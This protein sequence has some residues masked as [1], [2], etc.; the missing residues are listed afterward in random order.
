ML[1]KPDIKGIDNILQ[2]NDDLK[3]L[4]SNTEYKAIV[5][6]YVLNTNNNS[7]IFNSCYEEVFSTSK[8][9]LSIDG[10][11]YTV[12]FSS[13]DLIVHKLEP[14]N[15]SFLIG[16][17]IIKANNKS[18]LYGAIKYDKELKKKYDI[19]LNT[20]KD[21]YEMKIA[22]K[23]YDHKG[24]CVGQPL[25]SVKG[26][27]KELS[28]THKTNCIKKDSEKQRKNNSIIGKFIR[29]FPSQHVGKVISKRINNYGENKLVVESIDGH[30]MEVYDHP[31]C[32]AI[33]R[34]SSVRKNK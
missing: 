12:L 7:F 23:W 33:L 18:D 30:I 6:Y 8:K 2:F 5:P 16:D 11:Y 13:K 9:I 27:T 22:G 21:E 4:N 3:I 28:K 10:S 32:Y 25:P 26:P 1:K 20:N 29:I 15:D 31:Y 19:K 34:P 24:K 14:N 17:L